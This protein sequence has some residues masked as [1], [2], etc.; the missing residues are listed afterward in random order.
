VQV[1][2]K[3]QEIRQCQS[4]NLFFDKPAKLKYFL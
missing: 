2:N 3:C 1:K 4:K